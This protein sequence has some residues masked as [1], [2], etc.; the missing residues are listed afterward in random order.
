MALLSSSELAARAENAI[1]SRTFE[2]VLLNIGTDL[3]SANSSYTSLV[4]KEVST[5]NGGYTRIQFSFTSSDIVES[6]TGAKTAKRFLTWFHD[7]TSGEIVFDA[8]LI[9]ERIAAQPLDQYNVV[10]LESLGI[11]YT[12]S[13]A[14]DRGRFSF[15]INVRDK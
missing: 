7:G 4:A 3:L 12:L 10:A 1:T 13:L 5:D 15:S 6:A 8:L 2:A 11:P 9:V 14:G